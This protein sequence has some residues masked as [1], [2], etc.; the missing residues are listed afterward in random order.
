MRLGILVLRAILAV[1]LG[2]CLMIQAQAKADAGAESLVVSPAIAA[3]SGW[4]SPGNAH[5]P[6]VWSSIGTVDRLRRPP[7]GASVDS[8]PPAS[9]PYIYS[10]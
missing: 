9:V 5:T 1:V 4:D 7:V 3:T 6:R 2:G 10:V 8:A